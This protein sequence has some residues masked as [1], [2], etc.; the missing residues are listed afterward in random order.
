MQLEFRVGEGARSDV[1]TA[2]TQVVDKT[3]VHILYYQ[4]SLLWGYR[5]L[6]TALQGDPSFHLSAILNPALNMQLTSTA[7]DGP[8]MRD[9]PEDAAAL[10][11]FQVVILANVFA[12]Q[13]STR[14]QTALVNY[15]RQGGA[16]LFITPDSGSSAQFAGSLLEQMLPVTFSPPPAPGSE[17]AAEKSFQQRMNEA[18]GADGEL[19]TGFADQMIAGQP[20][21]TELLPFKAPPGGDARAARLFEAGPNAPKFADYTKVNNVKPGAEVLAVHPDDHSAAGG[22]PR[23]LLARQVFGA[24]SSA[25][26][27]TDL[28]WR[29][30]MS[31]PSESR[32]V[33]TFWQQFM[34]LLTRTTT[35]QGLRLVKD[36]SA[37]AQAG[38][39]VSV[40]VESAAGNP[41]K[42]EVVS[43]TGAKSA[44]A[45]DS[46]GGNLAGKVT[47]TPDTEGRWE[48]TATDAAGNFARIT[49][50]VGARKTQVESLDDPVDVE[51][52]RKLA[53]ATGGALVENTTAAIQPRIETPQLPETKRAR[54]LWDTQWLIAALL[55]IY[56]V[57][58]VLRRIA[59]LL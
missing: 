34:L 39:A 21:A 24:G 40:Q 36:S 1:A 8:A 43:P 15:V 30:K 33:E 12:D 13:L 6:L 46:Q 19:E 7:P 10:K 25:V 55:G 44:L 41:P 14:R 9:L 18:G 27:A 17:G 54:P 49:I 23:V 58:L 53:E 29:W 51:S 48:L 52:L 37:P 57:E 20:P 4:G 56:G 59:K 22:K 38:R 47:F 2:T 3:D 5:Y 45:F 31:V 16:V 50:P 32:V 11:R 26:L 28:L 35:G 42:V